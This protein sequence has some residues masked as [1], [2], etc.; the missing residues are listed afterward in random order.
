MM[1][2]G[3]PYV[4]RLYVTGSTSRSLQAIVNLK[5]ICEAHLP[6]RYELD[7]IDV[8]QQPALAREAK[9][10]ATPTLVRVQPPPRRTLTGT[11]DDAAEV[12]DLIGLTRQSNGTA[13]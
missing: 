10:V 2:P 7:V 1:E 6:G 4:L 8:Y 9:V 11:L 13:L 12:L 5:A 3:R